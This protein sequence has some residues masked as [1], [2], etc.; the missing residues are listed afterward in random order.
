MSRNA[1][2]TD[3]KSYFHRSDSAF[4]AACLKFIANATRRLNRDL[5]VQEMVTEDTV[6]LASARADLPTD[7]LE[8]R[9]VW[10]TANSGL[11]VMLTA[12]GFHD[13]PWYGTQGNTLVYALFG[14]QIWGVP[15]NDQTLNLVYYKKLAELTG[16]SSTNDIL[17]NYRHLYLSAAMMDAARWTQDPEL[18]SQ[19]AETYAAELRQ[20]NDRAR[21]SQAG[22]RP[23]MNAQY[24][25]MARHV[26]G[27]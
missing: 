14:D 22:A 7:F 26:R 4:D 3:I 25:Y 13:L 24:P 19:N 21:E 12:V 10:R 8:M 16:A 27:V 6:T 5:R 9:T 11:P 17:D 20:A 23:T 2:R 15:D 18:F 1:L